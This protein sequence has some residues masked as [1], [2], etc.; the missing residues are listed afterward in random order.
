MIY[1]CS[2]RINVLRFALL[3]AAFIVA[4]PAALAQAPGVSSNAPV[5]LPAVT[6]DSGGD[7]AESIAIAD[8][9]GD[10]RPDLV[11]ANLCVTTTPSNCAHGLVDG[12]VGVLLGKGDGRF[13][14]V[15]AYTST[16]LQTLSVAVA[17]VNG[18]GKP[19]LIVANRYACARLCAHGSVVIRLGNGDGTFQSAV[20]YDSGGGGAWSV[21]VADVNA[22]G[23]PDLLVANEDNTTAAVLLGQGDGTFQPA[24]TYGLG[25]G[26]TLSLAVADVNGDGKPDLLVATCASSGCAR[27]AVAVLVGNGDGT[28]QALV[29]YD[30]GGSQ[31][32]APAAADVNG[33]GEPDLIVAN[34]YPSN[35]I[36]VLLG[37]GDGTFQ[38]AVVYGPG[39]QQ[40]K[41]VAVADV[42]GDGKP[43]VLVANIAYTAALLLGNG[44]GTFQSAVDYNSGGVYPLSIAAADLNGDGK[45]DLVV[46][47]SSGTGNSDGTVGVL[48]SISSKSATST[49]LVSSLNPSIYGQKV[50]WIA[51][52]TTSRTVA[53]T[54]SVVFKGKD[55]YGHTFVIGRATL[56]SGGVATLIKSNLNVNVYQVTAVYLGDTMNQGSTSSVLNQMVRET[57]SKTVFNSS[58]NPA[59]Q[60]QVVTFTA[61][62]TSPTVAPTGPVTFIV[63]R[64]VLGTAQIVPWAHKAT[65]AISAL[66]AG[67][68][69]VTATY[70]G[71]S[72]IAASSASLTQTVQ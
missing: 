48:L 53:P 70:L 31:P 72:N 56:D 69:V 62:I 11:V 8:L 40:P 19:D 21:A 58:Q 18:D 60:G 6:Y 49:T 38:S 63:G 5:F 13:Q 9:N 20:A 17:D 41:S 3:Y 46:G 55:M 16:G 50:T 15:M 36:G 51:K 7:Y 45:L 47:N 39:G 67:S 2:T 54:G 26:G 52:V 1:K 61:M 34:Y 4:I 22:D 23:K 42:N 68:T 12:S 29:S 25:G 44:D 14:P 10:G 27:G 57:T 64:Q 30:S 65:L 24:L 37:N 32:I 66:P 71:D 35:S 28:F 43:D 33:D 59:A